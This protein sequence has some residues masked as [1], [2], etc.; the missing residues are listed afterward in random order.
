[1]SDAPQL[2]V[3]L[4]KP[5]LDDLDGYAAALRRGW[6]PT[7]IEDVSR[8]ELEKLEAGPVAYLDNLLA[9]DGVIPLPDG[10]SAPR[11]PSRLFFI[12]DGEFCGRINLR[13]APG[14]TDL[15]PYVSGHIGYTVVYWKSGRGYATE[16][17]RQLLP[18]AREV[19]L[20]FVTITCDTDNYASRR[21]IEKNGGVLVGERKD[22]F[23]DVMKLVFRVDV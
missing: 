12:D 22:N 20:P 6:S 10:T 18:L 3:R 19:G 17:L 15:P 4:R 9:Q 7:T 16:A 8:Q 11:L 23:L 14:T 5:T 13:Y 1:M 21:V 2:P